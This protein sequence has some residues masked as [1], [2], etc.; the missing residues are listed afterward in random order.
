[1]ARAEPPDLVLADVMMP[2][3]DGFG[4][5]RALRD[6]P[7]TRG[8]PVILLSARAGEEAARR[9]PRAG[10][11]DYLVKP[12]AARELL[13]RVR[14]QIRREHRPER[15]A[16]PERERRPLAAPGHEPGGPV[17]L[18]SIRRENGVLRME[19]PA[20]AGALRALRRE[21]RAFLARGGVARDEADGLVVAACE[22]AT[23]SIEHARDMTRP[24]IEVSAGLDEDRMRID[25]L[26]SGQWQAR[27]PSL[28][29]GR[30]SKLMEAFADVRVRPSPEGTLV[31]LFSR[32]VGD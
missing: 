28:D 4:L 23:N 6:D 1:M 11:D 21:L 7:A 32:P 8:I 19:V 12:F 9:G 31:T 3:L 13:A 26:D 16:P 2:R 14:A 27:G 30:G 20:E 18:L 22:A 29:R 17:E 15:G 10:A 5:L 25:V 24:V